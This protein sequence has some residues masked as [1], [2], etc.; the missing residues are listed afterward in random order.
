MWQMASARASAASA[1]LGGALSR[2]RRVTMAPTWALSARPLPVTAALTSLGGV[3]RDGDAAAGGAEHGDGAGLGGAHH[4]TDV[5]LAEHPL[6]GHEFGLVLVQP[7]LDALL[8]GDEAVAQLGVHGRPYDADAEHGERASGDALDHADSASGQ[9][10]VHPQYTHPGTFRSI[11]CL[12]RLSGAT[13]NAG[14]QLPAKRRADGCV[15]SA[16]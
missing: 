1:G 9:P 13:D 3:Q 5:V 12:C 2:S 7:L 8:D 15:P 6:H 4:R 10:R 16:R 11:A 14:Q